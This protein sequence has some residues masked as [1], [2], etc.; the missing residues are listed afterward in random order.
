MR[1]QYIFY[2]GNELYPV[3]FKKEDVTDD[4]DD[5]DNDVVG[6]SAESGSNKYNY[7]NINIVYCTEKLPSAKEM[8]ECHAKVFMSKL[9]ISSNS[10]FAFGLTYTPVIEYDVVR[11][12]TVFKDTLLVYVTVADTPAETE[13]E[14]DQD[15]SRQLTKPDKNK[16]AKAINK[17]LEMRKNYKIFGALTGILGVA[18]GLIANGSNPLDWIAPGGVLDKTQKRTQRQREIQRI[19]AQRQLTKLVGQIEDEHVQRQGHLATRDFM[20]GRDE[21]TT[22][23]RW[24]SRAEPI[25]VKEAPRS[26]QL[27]FRPDAVVDVSGSVARNSGKASKATAERA[28]P[29]AAK[30]RARTTPIAKKIRM[31][32]QVEAKPEHDQEEE[33]P[34]PEE[35]EEEQEYKPSANSKI[36]EVYA[37][38][39]VSADQFG[40]FSSSQAD[41]FDL[42]GFTVGGF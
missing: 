27:A 2:D 8:Y 4:D 28:R 30:V 32:Q 33:K 40:G 13:M 29:V 14:K 25:R 41:G 16:L 22:A 10:T 18:G 20:G 6:V 3:T 39:A 35:E 38:S 34:E 5:E 26:E 42:S 15:V 17:K 11:S 37:K 24:Q 1:V 19:V 21:A 7:S 36:H 12:F 9:G 31:L 23:E